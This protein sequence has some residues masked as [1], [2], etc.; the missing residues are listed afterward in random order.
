MYGLF[1]APD[2]VFGLETENSIDN[3]RGIYRLSVLGKG[4]VILSFF[5]AVSK[6]VE[7][8]K[9]Y[10]IIIFSLLFI[11]IVMHVIRQIIAI[12]FLVSVYY[13][14]KK[15]RYLWLW[16][17]FASILLIPFVS[18]KVDDNTLIGKLIALSENQIEAHESGEEN[19]RISEY[20]YFFTEYSKNAFTALFG[21]GIPHSES[22]FGKRELKINKEKKYFASDVGYAEIYMRFGLV[23]LILYAIIFYRVIIQVVPKKYM[24]AKLFMIY[25]LISNIGASWIFQDVIV[26]CI[27]LYILETS[28]RRKYKLTRLGAHEIFNRNTRLQSK[29]SKRMYR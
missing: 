3:V 15:N 10:W 7:T 8:S 22:V 4:F 16:V 11:V 14:L 17:G 18:Y 26:I 27:C 23:G 29:I 5:F 9:K 21:N 20:R 12:S 6:F 24:Y 1:K 25:I 28:N 13:L 2:I 19:I